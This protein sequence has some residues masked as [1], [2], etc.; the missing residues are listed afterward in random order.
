MKKII[1]SLLLA[2]S[3]FSDTF[4]HQ[5]IAVESSND[6]SLQNLFE[7]AEAKKNFFKD[8]ENELELA[9]TNVLNIERDR[10]NLRGE[11]E[12]AIKS[13]TESFQTKLS[14]L[15]QGAG[16]S[17]FGNEVFDSQIQPII[18]SIEEITVAN[19]KLV[20]N[21]ES[22]DSE[23]LKA[24]SEIQQDTATKEEK[25]KELLA[26]KKKRGALVNNIELP[27][28]ENKI[29]KLTQSLEQL[30]GL[31][32]KDKDEIKLLISEKS[33]K[34]EE[35]V[36][37]EAQQSNLINESKTIQVSKGQF[38]PG[39]KILASTAESDFLGLAISTIRGRI[40]DIDNRLNSL[41]SQQVSQNL[42]KEKL[43]QELT[44]F[45]NEYRKKTAA[46]NK[47][48][49]STSNESAEIHGDTNTASIEEHQILE[50][51]EKELRKIIADKKGNIG[52]NK[53]LVE[54][55]LAKVKK[56]D[57][58]ISEN[59]SEREKQQKLLEEK[60]KEIGD[61]IMESLQMKE[62]SGKPLSAAEQ[63]VKQ[64]V[65]SLSPTQRF[66]K[67]VGSMISASRKAAGSMMAS[68]KVNKLPDLVENKVKYQDPTSV[69]DPLI[70]GSPVL[71]VKTLK[72][73][74]LN[75]QDV[76]VYEDKQV[77]E[78]FASRP[79]ASTRLQ[80]Q[81]RDAESFSRSKVDSQNDRHSAVAGDLAVS[82][83]KNQID[84][85]SSTSEKP[86]GESL[87]GSSLASPS[88]S[89]DGDQQRQPSSKKR[90]HADVIDSAADT[91]KKIRL[92][93][94]IC[95]SGNLNCSGNSSSTAVRPNSQIPLDPLRV[96]NSVSNSMDRGVKF[97]ADI[98]SQPSIQI[99]KAEAHSA[100]AILQ[101]F[102]ADM[103]NPD[104]QKVVNKPAVRNAVSLE[105]NEANLN[106][107][108]KTS[109][110]KVILKRIDHN[111]DRTKDSYRN[112]KQKIE[113]AKAD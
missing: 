71:N 49:P 13:Y 46:L 43:T 112:L 3:S 66:R 38:Q 64:Q 14:S 57:S 85:V 47:R 36:A 78:N 41:N 6:R 20:A 99:S 10:D 61:K 40:S 26:V 30:N 73:D 67:A 35:M 96:E 108:L 87:M 34:E 11:F 51:K 56:I 111:D 12:A 93:D 37:K 8:K 80:F 55:L 4:V 91:S 39:Q 94:S 53:V 65:Q 33:Q 15:S 68:K 92:N 5:S 88:M 23:I 2:T 50:D 52:R 76:R 32:E 29:D 69:A 24:Q 77:S 19:K 103:R 90:S 48:N 45:E 84:S 62:E 109:M 54:Q 107:S 44:K 74:N 18:T 31:I 9:K 105:I 86:T 1:L 113:A 17:F 83:G 104:N 72:D 82:R 110:L 106:E 97:S 75:N 22:L 59:Q 27:K 89:H 102:E 95:D 101:K 7:N 70:S 100:S 21:K 63:Q 58:E 81:S 16:A 98:S 42:I 79:S 28:I 25:E 60:T